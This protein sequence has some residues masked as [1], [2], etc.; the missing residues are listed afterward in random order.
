M[1]SSSVVTYF[2][3]PIV[4]NDGELA[5]YLVYCT[6]EQKEIFISSGFTWEHLLFS[7]W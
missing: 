1:E 6:N 3:A 7:I 2:L 4:Q 5:F